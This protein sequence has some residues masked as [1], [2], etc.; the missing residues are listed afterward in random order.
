MEII[1]LV[2]LFPNKYIVQKRLD[3]FSAMFNFFK[4]YSYMIKKCKRSKFIKKSVGH[5]T[6]VT[7]FWYNNRKINS[8]KLDD[9]KNVPISTLLIFD[10]N[11][12]LYQFFF[13]DG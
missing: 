9:Q 11:E 13:S 5:S 1:S 4:F 3:R 8:C 2:Q 6:I 7:Q 10:N 12:I